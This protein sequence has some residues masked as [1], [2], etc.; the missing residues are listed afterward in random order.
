MLNLPKRMDQFMWTREPA[1]AGT[2]YPKEKSKLMAMLEQFCTPLI[3]PKAV[4]AIVAPHAGYIYSGRIAGEVYRRIT[5]PDKVIIAC[6][7]HTGQGKKIS[8]WQEGSWK[9]PLGEVP[10][11]TVLAK[12]FLTEVGENSGDVKAHEY[13][14]AIEVHIPFLQ[15]RNPK[16]SILPIVLGPLHLDS[17]EHVARALAQTVLSQSEPV[18]LVASTDMSHYISAEQAKGK[19]ALALKAIENLNHEELYHTVVQNEIS[20]CGFIP[21]TC[22]LGAANKL[23]AKHSEIV[24]Y[25]N[26]GDTTQDFRSVVAYAGALIR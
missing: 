12:A 10:V 4:L 17:C 21:T 6:P 3:T 7:N 1:V 23:G 8:V 26:S 13:E 5:I 14:H 20:M 9:T 15:S 11:N 2:F 18:L 24:A 19:D 25:G 22:I 16:V